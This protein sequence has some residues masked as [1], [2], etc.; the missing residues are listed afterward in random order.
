MNVSDSGGEFRLAGEL[1]NGSVESGV[2]GA[3]KRGCFGRDPEVEGLQAWPEDAR[4]NFRQ[5]QCHP[6]TLRRQGVTKLAADRL[7]ET[8]TLE[9][10]QIVAHLAGGVVGEGD[11]EQL[12]HQRAQSSVGDAIWREHK[13]AQRAEQR[14]DARI[15]EL[16][17]WSWLTLRGATRSRQGTQLGLAEPAVMGRPFQMQQPPVDALS[18]GAEVGEVTQTPSNAKIMR[19][20]EGGLGAQSAP[21]LEEASMVC[22]ARFRDGSD[23]QLAVLQGALAWTFQELEEAACEMALEAALDLARALAFDGASRDVGLRFWVMHLARDDDRV[24]GAVELAIA[25]TVQAMAGNLPR[26]SGDR[27]YTRQCSEGRL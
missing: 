13:E 23:S 20:V 11:A 5:E 3:K 7:N 22:Q 24:Q 2:R 18:Q 9:S 6:P 26:R 15:A 12:R 25:G 16:E 27:R 10:A 21:R 17:G 19:V 14:G 4:L 8:L 1:V